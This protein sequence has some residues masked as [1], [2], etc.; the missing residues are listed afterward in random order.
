MIWL[1]FEFPYPREYGGA[2]L[3]GIETFQHWHHVDI[4]VIEQTKDRYLPLSGP[5]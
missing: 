3:Q 4:H 2:L 5:N 1:H